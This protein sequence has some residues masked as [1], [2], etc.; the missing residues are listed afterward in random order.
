[1][2]EMT[3]I[4][5]YGVVSAPLALTIQ[6]KLPGPI[7]RI[8]TYLTDSDLRRQ[9]LASG[10]MPREAGSAFELTWRNDELA[11]SP[12]GR[13]E[14]FPAE[15]SMQS[16]VLVFEPPHRLV[17]SWPPSGEVSF[18]LR[19]VGSEVL[20]TL[21][22]QRISDRRNMVMIGAGWHMHLDILAARASGTQPE[23]FWQGWSRVKQEYERIIPA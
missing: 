20:L 1:M 7:E 11:D 15:H 10:I 18:E 8:W 5:T 4:D 23:S 17:F 2:N 22:H 13:P 3:S 14:G 6:R 9:W 12:E 21:T 16:E 19:T